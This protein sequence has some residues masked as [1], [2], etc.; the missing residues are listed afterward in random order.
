MEVADQGDVSLCSDMLKLYTVKNYI[1]L[2]SGDVVLSNDIL[3][4]SWSI[5]DMMFDPIKPARVRVGLYA[6]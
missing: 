3:F 4:V 5:L 1:L 2:E 6:S